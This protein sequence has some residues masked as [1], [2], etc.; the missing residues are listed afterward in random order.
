[1]EGGLSEVEVKVL[2]VDVVE[3]GGSMYT[4]GRSVARDRGEDAIGG[5]GGITEV[6][7]ELPQVKVDEA[8][9]DVQ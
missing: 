2:Q 1:M 4:G 3:D 9:A 7:G 8:T 5:C 6:K